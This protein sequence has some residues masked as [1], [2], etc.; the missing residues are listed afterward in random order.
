MKIHLFATAAILLS[1]CAATSCYNEGP[2]NP[3][4][5]HFDVDP[6]SW[7]IAEYGGYPA[8]GSDTSMFKVIPFIRPVYG[9]TDFTW[10][11]IGL[12]ILKEGIG[13]LTDYTKIQARTALGDFVKGLIFGKSENPTMLKLDEIIGKLDD[14]QK[15]LDNLQNTMDEVQKKI[16]EQAFNDFRRDL[17]VVLNLEYAYRTHTRRYYFQLEKA[18]TDDE[19]RKILTEWATSNVSGNQACEQG[20]NFIKQFIGFKRTYL[21][22]D[23]TVF[24]LYDLVAFDNY[25]WENEGYESRETFRGTTAADLLLGMTMSYMYFCMNNEDEMADTCVDALEKAL[26]YFEANPLVKSK[27]AV[28]QIDGAYLSFDRENCWYER[29]GAEFS[30]KIWLNSDKSLFNPFT[31]HLG[32]DDEIAAYK[33]SQMTANEYNILLSYY[34]NKYPEMALIE[35]LEQEQGIKIPDQL[36]PKYEILGEEYG[37]KMASVSSSNKF[38]LQDSNVVM[39]DG[40]YY[41]SSY[42]KKFRVENMRYADLPMGAL[43]MTNGSL[44][45]K[46]VNKIVEG[47]GNWGYDNEGISDWK[48][49][50]TAKEAVYLGVRDTDMP[51]YRQWKVSN[52]YIPYSSDRIIAINTGALSRYKTFWDVQ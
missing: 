38:L 35:V 43:C 6:D 13:M 40:G 26:S 12:S 9:I 31:D 21:A 18:T 47:E 25:A 16:D 36:K 51:H 1:L 32:T 34:K 24:G 28:C 45:F 33:A 48:D 41:F 5:I 52:F 17:D 42:S 3:K 7:D 19:I 8:V 44:P 20:F 14:I 23:L 49:K 50:Y 37:L 29:K 2:E 46:D 27:R 11:G 10:T 30:S 4:P 39:W 22:H 15:Q